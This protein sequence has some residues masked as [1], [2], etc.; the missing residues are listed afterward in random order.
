MLRDMKMA[1]WGDEQLVAAKEAGAGASA[2][3]QTLVNPQ[4]QQYAY[5]VLNVAEQA[6]TTLRAVQAIEQIPGFQRYIG[7]VPQLD[8]LLQFA[9]DS[10]TKTAGAANVTLMQ[11]KAAEACGIKDRPGW[12]GATH[13]VKNRMPLVLT[14][15]LS[16]EEALQLDKGALDVARAQAGGPGGQARASAR[17]AL[18]MA[19]GGRLGWGREEEVEGYLNWDRR[20]E[21]ERRFNSNSR[22]RFP[23]PPGKGRDAYSGE[24]DDRE[25]Y[26]R[27][28]WSSRSRSPDTNGRDRHQNWK[29]QGGSARGAG[30]GRDSRSRD[31][32]GRY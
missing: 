24:R 13:Y 14:G 32:Q 7:E 3:Y 11:F 25:N 10:A 12:A 15:K 30:S 26:R 18:G 28:H 6:A 5:G 2:V 27:R 8:K 29:G 31:R 21:E 23:S 4:C 1:K 20:D 22:G 17:D 16:P 19:A 9:E